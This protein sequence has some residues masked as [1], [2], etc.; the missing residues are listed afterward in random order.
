VIRRV[1]VV[2]L[3]GVMLAGCGT[4][5]PQAATKK[6]IETTN[7]G[8][9]FVNLNDD[10]DRTVTYLH[11][12][13]RDTL[14]LRTLC[15]VLSLDLHKMND[16]LPSPDAQ[17]NSLLAKGLDTLSQGTALCASATGLTPVSP[18]TSKLREGFGGV[19]FGALRLWGLAGLSGQP[20]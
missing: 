8:A 17:G 16:S 3:A 12:S 11:R 10:L 6:W 18:I 4:I 7:F 9:A 15:R 13:Q 19:Y 20:H 14:E 2:V 1:A 5:S